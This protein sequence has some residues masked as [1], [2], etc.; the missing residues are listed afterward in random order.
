M[1]IAGVDTQGGSQLTA[2][3]NIQ[4][5]SPADDARAQEARDARFGTD[6]T[7][8]AE[9]RQDRFGTQSSPPPG[10]DSSVP[11]PSLDSQSLSALIQATQEQDTES[12]QA[13][14]EDEER[15]EEAGAANSTSSLL[16]GATAQSGTG[17]ADT[18][19]VSLFV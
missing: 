11:G 13:A 15:Q 10:Q 4:Q 2:L 12:A 18:R 9:A 1:A 6:D 8:E 3:R 5:P 7:S 17:T 14:N 16:P 19:G